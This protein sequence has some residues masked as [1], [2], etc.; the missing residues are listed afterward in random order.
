MSRAFIQCRYSSS[1][2]NLFHRRSNSTMQR[3]C[4]RLLIIQPCS[5][6]HLNTTLNMFL[7]YLLNKYFNI[8]MNFPHGERTLPARLQENITFLQPSLNKPN[9]KQVNSNCL[10][11]TRKEKT[12]FGCR[13]YKL[14]DLTWGVHRH[15]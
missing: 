15:F 8:Q 2:M 9:L 13:V 1:Y 6:F 12:Y 5:P 14:D 10:T 7:L 4:S 3:M 11:P